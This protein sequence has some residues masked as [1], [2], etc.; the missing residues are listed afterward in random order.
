MWNRT[1]AW[2][3]RREKAPRL[4]LDCAVTIYKC[5]AQHL[6][7]CKQHET[8]SDTL[9]YLIIKMYFKRLQDPSDFNQSKYSF[10][11]Y[12]FKWWGYHSDCTKKSSHTYTYTHK[13][14][15]ID[16]GTTL[17]I[18]S[19]QANHHNQHVYHRG[20]GPG[21]LQGQTTSHENSKRRHGT[22]TWFVN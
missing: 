22:Y 4:Y 3:T 18:S 19:H 14:I 17:C 9:K 20:K 15:K 7:S 8:V 12:V 5:A 6:F 1:P 16:F 13:G 10:E 11:S 21:D 2:E